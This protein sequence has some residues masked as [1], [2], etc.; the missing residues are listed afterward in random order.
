MME[1]TMDQKEVAPDRKDHTEVRN[2]A[3]PKGNK[4][5]GKTTESLG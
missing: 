3:D 4:N 1:T 5:A 2:K